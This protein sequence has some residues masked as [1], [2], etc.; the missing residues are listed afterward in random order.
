LTKVANL[1]AL[2]FWPK[3]QTCSTIFFVEKNFYPNFYTINKSI[4]L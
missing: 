2:C 3:L 4:K 1:V